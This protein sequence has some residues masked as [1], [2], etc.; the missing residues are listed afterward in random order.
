MRE[1]RFRGKRVDT[2]EWVYGHYVFAG[3]Y[4]DDPVHRIIWQDGE[5]TSH[6]VIVDPETVSECSGI[7]GKSGKDIYEGDIVRPNIET[8][9]EGEVVQSVFSKGYF[10]VTDAAA[11][12]HEPLFL[13]ANTCEVI[14]NIY[15]NPEL[16]K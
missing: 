4:G 11:F 6:S 13:H 9:I 1:I 10:G 12:E 8:D 16:L 7:K 2:G 15:E 5:G 14:G 3:V